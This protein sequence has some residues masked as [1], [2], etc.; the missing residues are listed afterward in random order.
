M[1]SFTKAIDQNAT[2]KYHIPSGVQKLHPHEKDRS[3]M[4][5][6]K[7]QNV[8]VKQSKDTSIMKLQPTSSVASDVL[9][10]SGQVNFDVRSSNLVNGKTILEA[11]VTNNDSGSYEVQTLQFSG[12]GT[13]WT[14]NWQIMYK[15]ELSYPLLDDSNIVAV[16]AALDA[17]TTVSNDG[18]ATAVL[19]S[20]TVGGADALFTITWDTYGNK[21]QIYAFS[22]ATETTTGVSQE[23][24][25]ATTT[26]G[27]APLKLSAHQLVDRI[28][29]VN[30][31]DNSRESI[32]KDA[33]F[34]Q[35]LFVNSEEYSL[36]RKAQNLSAHDDATNPFVPENGIVPGGSDTL[37]LNIPNPYSDAKLYLGALSENIRVEVHFSNN[38]IHSG[39]AVV[40]D[41]A[42]SNVVMWLYGENLA[43]EEASDLARR[44]SSGKSHFRTVDY[45][46]FNINQTFASST[47]YTQNLNGL[48]KGTCGLLLVM[49]RYQNGNGSNEF[50]YE[51]ISSIELRD[52]D[53]N[54]AILPISGEECRYLFGGSNF[55]N[56]EFFANKNVYPLCFASDPASMFEGQNTG[57]FTISGSEQLVI[58][59]GTLSQGSGNYTLTCLQFNYQILEM[60]NGRPRFIK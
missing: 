47:E 22:A 44:L 23:I 59:T 15:G 17:M 20:G 50:T 51:P 21:S 26:T 37:Y 24:V 38:C 27:T 16:N 1:A 58:T 11:T 14:G 34:A 19:T 56:Q 12:T 10:N 13:A 33:L 42:L 49:L 60:D 9:S 31:H 6:K 39:D 3:G 4:N 18:G 32:P 2:N 5:L 55:P 41:L 52:Q 45:R 8:S 53:G 46:V 48:S 28:D 25:S 7:S 43:S 36:L 40:G 30:P 57:F 54:Q 29:F 35:N